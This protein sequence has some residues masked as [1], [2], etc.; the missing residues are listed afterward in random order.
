MKY[1]LKVQSPLEVYIKAFEEVKNNAGKD[2]Q[3]SND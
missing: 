2:R 3:V 1:I